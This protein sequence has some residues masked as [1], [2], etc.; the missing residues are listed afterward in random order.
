M[1]SKPTLPPSNV[2]AIRASLW[3]TLTAVTLLV[4][5]TRGS[6]PAQPQPA[7]EAREQTNSAAAFLSQLAWT[8]GPAQAS[9]G[10]MAEIQLPDGYVF[11]GAEGT[12]RLLRAWGNPTSG[13]ELGFLAPAS[14]EWSVIFEFSD[15][16]YVKDEEKSKLDADK[17]LKSIREGTERSNPLREKMGAAPMHVTGWLQPPRYNSDTHHLEWAIRGESVG[18]AVVNYNTRLLGR[19]GVMS[20]TLVVDPDK[21]T[22]VLPAYQS[23]LQEYSFKTGQRYAEYRQGDKIAKYGLTALILGG[24]AVGAAKLGLLTW[25]AVLLKKVWKLIVLAIVAAASAIRR[26]LFGPSGRESRS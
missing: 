9:I 5:T 16:G 22:E 13:N 23:L 26:M 3:L 7:T 12:Q 20:A 17:L 4:P 19:K 14:L 8:K 21:M 6:D 24:A 18:R 11:T 15:V 2:A 25:A 10:Q 1:L